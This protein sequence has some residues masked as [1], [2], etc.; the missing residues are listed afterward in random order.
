MRLRLVVSLSTIALVFALASLFPGAGG[1]PVTNALA[2]YGYMG[3]PFFYNPSSAT[4]SLV[5]APTGEKPQ[6]KLWFN[7][8]RWWASMFNNAAGNYRIY[9]LDVASQTWKDTGTVLDTRAQT[10]ADCLWDGTHL[11]V[12]SGGGS[13][14][15]GTGTSAALPGWLYRYSYNPSTKQY[16]KDFGPVV[17]RNGGAETLV[18][19]KDST[20]KLWITYTQNSKV[21]VNHSRASDSSWDPALAMVVPTQQ[22]SWA[23]VSPDDISTLVAYDN[24]IGVLWSNESAGQ[25][26]G[27]SDTAFYFAYHVD[28]QPDTS[29][30]SG[31]IFRAPAGAD[32]HL[33]IKS[34]QA[35]S[36]G[37]LFAM[38]KTSFNS[39][40]TPQL[41]LLV[42]KKQNGIYS[43]NWY[44]ESIR[45][46][47][48]TRPL[49]L[50]DT[51]HRTLYVFTSDEGGGSIY[52][53]TSSM[54]TIKFTTGANTARTFMSK[55]GYTINNLTGTK[56]TVNVSTGIAVLA[57]HDNQSSVDSPAADYYFHNYI[58]LN[59][60]GP[61]VTP[62]GPTATAT[63]TA[64]ATPRPTSTP[65]VT[66]T[67]TISPINTPDQVFVPV[68]LNP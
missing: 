2:P 16:T 57:S 48:Q 1:V 52:Y 55:P 67:P 51:S 59:S 62:S 20:G 25:F 12:A 7:D 42:A 60:A 11:Y 38:V 17:I 13:D 22:S 6:S 45:E 4:K 36:A 61:T 33:N 43:W 31:P 65:T 34:L 68:A 9:W 49:L 44:T 18:L 53:K 30:T 54:D 27:S 32:D 3:L 24:K 39:S 28:G 35:D 56:Q 63:R 5:L 64:T 23:N 46:E 66:S 14:V 21:Y 8:G 19:D 37:N 41:I 29:W 10:K 15:N 40:G 50:I 58:D 26:S 47:G